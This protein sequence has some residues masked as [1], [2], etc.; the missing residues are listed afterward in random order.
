MARVELACATE[1]PDE[2]DIPTLFNCGRELPI[3][4]LVLLWG[5]GERFIDMAARDIN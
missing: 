5:E 1:E 2:D 4:F 3:P